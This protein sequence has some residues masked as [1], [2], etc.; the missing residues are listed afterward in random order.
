MFRSDTHRA[1][2][3]SVASSTL[4]T[5]RFPCGPGALSFV[6][7]PS[8]TTSLVPQAR[9]AAVLELMSL[10]REPSSRTW[11]SSWV[12]IRPFPL[13]MSSSGGAKTSA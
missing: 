7:P 12:V 4:L 1:E 9:R 8:G 10:I 3:V 2:S 5:L 6:P 11:R 13:I